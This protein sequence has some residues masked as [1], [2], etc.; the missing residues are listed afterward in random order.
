V[1]WATLSGEI[2]REPKAIWDI[3][4]LKASA[5]TALDLGP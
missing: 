1:E 5:M 4:T 3:G 2:D